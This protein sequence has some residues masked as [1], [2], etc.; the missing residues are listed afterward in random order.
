MFQFFQ[1]GEIP[2][3]FYPKQLSRGGIFFNDVY[4][5]GGV[6]NWT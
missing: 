1:S 4:K 6:K 5:G 2:H 3:L